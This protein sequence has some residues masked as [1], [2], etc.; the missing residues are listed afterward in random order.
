MIDIHKFS[1]TLREI[2]DSLARTIKI[3]REQVLEI[4]VGDLIEKYK[5]NIRNDEW[6]A[7]F[8]KVLRYYLDKDEMAE[9]KKAIADDVN[10]TRI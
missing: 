9:L 2:D 8:E 7:A 1:E 3:S 10:N 4:V 5:F 6:S